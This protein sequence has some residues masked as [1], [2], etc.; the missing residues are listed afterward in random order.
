[1]QPFTVSAR[2]AG[3]SF[4]H[5]SHPGAGAHAAIGAMHSQPPAGHVADADLRA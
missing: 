2:R 4:G 3:Q 5:S 1:M